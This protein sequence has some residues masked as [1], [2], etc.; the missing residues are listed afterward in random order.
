MQ[1]DTY[2]SS[3]EREQEME[4]STYVITLQWPTVSV[5]KTHRG[6]KLLPSQPSPPHYRV[7]A[8]DIQP[9]YT[10]HQNLLNV[11]NGMKFRRHFDRW[12]VVPTHDEVIK[13]KH[14]PRYW[15]FVREIHRSPVNSPHKGKWRG[16][17]V[18]S[19]ICA[20]MNNSV[21]NRQAGDLRRHR[22][23]YHVTVL[24]CVYILMNG[25]K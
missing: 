25:E 11:W 5:T 4:R 9:W 15:S 3:G 18:Y 19:L 17:L 21:N 16:A 12:H 23:H 1:C 13:R 20:W 10:S 8:R 2:Q 7:I 6:C 14:F 22:A 24:R